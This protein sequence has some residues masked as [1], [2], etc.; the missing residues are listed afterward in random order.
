MKKIPFKFN[1]G[2]I[3]ALKI[4]IVD[5]IEK[6]KC[7]YIHSKLALLILAEFYK[8]NI[9]AFT[10]V[11]TKTLINFRES[12]AIAF[13]MLYSKSKTT[14]SSYEMAVMSIIMDKIGKNI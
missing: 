12:E 3:T 13:Y 7:E 6:Y 4:V 9:Q 14:Y 2:E 1:E 8:R 5:I 11:K 10:F